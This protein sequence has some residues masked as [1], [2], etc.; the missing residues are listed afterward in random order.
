MARADV[1]AGRA[2]V[3][4]YMRDKLTRDLQKAKQR[5][6][7]FGADMMSLGTKMVAMSAAIATPIG[8]AIAKF[9]QFD[10]AMRAVKAVTNA[11]GD[12]FDR[13]TEK[14]KSWDALPVSRRSK[15]PN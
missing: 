1:M 14:R 6:N 11:T 7:Q 15:S 5:V 2:Y 13:L 10:D 4:L 9:A 12:D 8:F 3:S